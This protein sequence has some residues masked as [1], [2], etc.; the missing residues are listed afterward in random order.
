MAALRNKPWTHHRCAA[1]DHGMSSQRKVALVA[2]ANGVIGR[3][4]VDHLAT[5]DDWDVI[6]LSRRG[7]DDTDRVRHLRVDLLD[8]GDCQDKL[9][10]LR[11]VTHVFYAAYQERPTWAELVPPNL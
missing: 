7:G 3:N 6:G 1:Q 8:R 4:L 9:G 2:G 10:N 5:L 11:E